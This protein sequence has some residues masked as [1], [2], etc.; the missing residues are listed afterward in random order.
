MVGSMIEMGETAKEPYCVGIDKLKFFLIP[1]VCFNTLGFPG[2][3]GGRIQ[4]L[5]GFVAPCFFILC[6][7]LVLLGDA[8]KRR[9]KLVRAIKRAGV[10]F[11]ALFVL[12]FLANVFYC[13]LQ[14]IDW[15]KIFTSK[16]SLFFFLALNAW[17]LPMG[18]PIWF[19]QALL[20]AYVFL[21]LINKWFDKLWVRR[22]LLIVCVVF[23][24]VTGEFA[25]LFGL[26]FFGIPY[27]PAGM[28]TRAL[29]YLLIGGLLREKTEGLFFL[30]P[31]AYPLLSVFFVALSYGEFT[32]LA[33][34]GILVDT[35]H[36]LCLG[37][38]AIALACW[39][40]VFPEASRDFIAFHGRPYSK[41]IYIFF[42]IVALGVILFAVFF[43]PQVA[44][45]I[46]NMGG[47]IVYV[48]C[49]IVA[50]SISGIKF[51]I[52]CINNREAED[53]W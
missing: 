25:G 22:G 46:V 37:L 2:Q 33:K 8:Q 9:E 6:G 48:I 36:S 27:L 42:Q 16:R 47:V 38:T 28:V 18:E 34:W 52:W 21:L 7:F 19:I 20:Y 12:F 13:S 30:P 14:H 29:P 23:M 40:I 26:K 15:L 17:P 51:M 41:W 49:M 1:F 45:E 50:L 32:M 39:G 44:G 35:S 24:L 43:M 10:T 11:L 3:F 4:S 31:F 5:S 53:E